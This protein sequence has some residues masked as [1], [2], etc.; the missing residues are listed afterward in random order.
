ML[1]VIFI[2]ALHNKAF[3]LMERWFCSCT[4]KACSCVVLL[5]II[6]KGCRYTA[7]YV[8]VSVLCWGRASPAQ[9]LNTNVKEDK[10][11]SNT[12][13]KMKCYFYLDRWS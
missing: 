13:F 1:F 7:F 9:I 8:T 4:Y 10:S 2:S 6:N 12:S 5:V 3:S 11:C